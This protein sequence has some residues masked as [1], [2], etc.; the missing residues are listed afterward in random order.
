MPVFQ[1]SSR[2]EQTTAVPKKPRVRI[3]YQWY[4]VARVIIA[5]HI[6]GLVFGFVVV[7]YGAS[8]TIFSISSIVFILLP[9][10]VS[11]LSAQFQGY[12]LSVFFK[13]TFLYLML[14]FCLY[15]IYYTIIVIAN[16]LI[17]RPAM[18]TPDFTLLFPICSSLAW[19]VMFDPLRL[20]L[21][22]FI[23]RRFNVRNKEEA[24]L[25]EDFAATLRQEID[26]DQLCDRFLTVIQRTLHPH[27]ISLWIRTKEQRREPSETLEEIVA[28][29]DDPLL[30]YTLR[31]S[32]IVEIDRLHLDSPILLEMKDRGAELLL[33]LTSQGELVGLLLL[34]PHLSG[35]GGLP[36]YILS[37]YAPRER[38]LLA[39][40][41]P[42]VAPALQVA[43][44][45]REEQAQVRERERI[46]QE[47]RTARTIQ[48]SL[49]PTTLPDPTGWQIAAYYKPAREVGGDFYD[50]VPFEDG[51]LGIV[52]GDVSGKGI[53]AAMLMSSTRSLLRAA[54][55]MAASPSEVLARVN[56]LLCA[57]TLPSMFVT[58]FYA[59]LDPISGRL[60]YANAGHDLPYRRSNKDVNELY[61]TGMPLG[62]LPGMQYE[63]QEALVTADEDILL[64][65][66]GL[67]EAHNPVREMFGFPRLKQL[68]AIF[69]S[70]TSGADFINFLLQ[71]LK[72]FTGEGWEQE[73]DVT[74]VVLQRVAAP[75]ADV[76][77]LAVQETR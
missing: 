65:S 76:E 57:D 56:E 14:T 53:P 24:K 10:L 11:F 31:H 20:Y 2:S 63:E 33:P 8:L 69:S 55:Q 26:L 27:S 42:Q 37:S 50:F 6:A 43:Q 12:D 32:G 17:F 61:A 5:M 13:G 48:E 70:D 49:L 64:Y 16:L 28:T 29:N 71:E 67:V 3:T 60:R 66:D 35:G 72:C 25:V 62:L 52:V 51:R 41:I 34:G 44:M 18:Q 7:R 1:I 73:D 77:L 36:S 45:V 46:E 75:P 38:N 30:A 22:R 4:F 23:E 54:A 68:M 39:S 47:L 19:A 21:Q 40:L 9:V 15:L 59:I 58:C 74:L